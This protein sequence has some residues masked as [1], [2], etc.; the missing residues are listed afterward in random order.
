MDCYS[1]GESVSFCCKAMGANGGKVIAL[2]NR[3]PSKIPSIEIKAILVYTL[4]GKPFQWW[5]PIEPKFAA[6]PRDRVAF[7]RFY[8]HL[9]SIMGER[10]KAPPIQVIEGRF[11]GLLEGL[12]LLRQEKGS[13][14]KLIVELV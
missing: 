14:R 10:L 6:S 4:A 7:V 12:G 3:G 8:D 13:G 2:L 5:A 1:E 9:P 11:D